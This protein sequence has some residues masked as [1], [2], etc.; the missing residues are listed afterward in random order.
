LRGPGRDA[1]PERLISS[2][3]W[4]G[5]V[6]ACLS[7]RLQTDA[8]HPIALS[9]SGGGDSIALLR[10]TCDWAKAHGRRVLALTVDHGL[11]ADSAGWTAF[12]GETARGA[13]AEWRAL[14][15]DGEKPTASLPAAARAARHRL[16]AGAAREAGA[17]VVLFAHTAGDVR[18]AEVMRAE[19]STLGRVR[20]WG[21]S[22]AWPEG[23]GLMLL[24]P[25]LGAGREEIR[26]WLVSQGARWIEDPGNED[27]KFARSR[28]RV[29][30]GGDR[31]A[32]VGTPHPPT[33]G[34]RGPLPLRMGEGVVGVGREVDGRT[35]A[36]VL[37]C[38][39]GGD[40]PLRGDRLDRL[41]ARLGAGD[42]FVAV[43]GGSRIEADGDRVTVMREAGEIARHGAGPL[44]LAP[45]V[46]TVW[47][48][49][50]AVRVDEPGWSV[51][52]AAGRR[53]GMSKAD[54]A[55]LATM[56]PGARGA[57]PVLI[58]DDPPAA[59]LAAPTG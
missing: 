40:R 13:G 3:A 44:V 23:R 50:W 57:Q 56:P 37:V 52:A 32:G 14:S 45:G 29:V 8:V 30:L 41:I 10:L 17:R 7:A 47:D 49:R 38:V 42:D 9:L 20:E 31:L 27:L 34:A 28:A 43:L 4:T 5:A 59:I 12:A 19:G 33:R 55:R 11:N 53:G 26:T 25:M 18:E 35:L 6:H 36:A 58:R 46:E 2:D 54:R 15:W 51:A 24:R 21:P 39:G 1:G 16:L 22:P 48:G